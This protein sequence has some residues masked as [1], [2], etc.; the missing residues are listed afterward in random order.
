MR[1]KK[2]QSDYLTR[3]ERAIADLLLRR[4]RRMTGKDIARALDSTPDSIKVM[5]CNMRKKGVTIT[6]GGVGQSSVG[7]R[8]EGLA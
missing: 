8:L 1:L 5:V 3:G 4:H 6:G 7:Y 2:R